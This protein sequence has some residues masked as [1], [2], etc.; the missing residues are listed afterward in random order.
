M[1]NDS[2]TKESRIW[3]GAFTL[4]YVATFVALFMWGSCS[5]TTP[6]EHMGV[7][8]DF[9]EEEMGLDDNETKVVEKPTK[10]EPTPPKGRP[11]EPK[12][13]NPAPKETPEEAPA[14]EPAMVDDL[15]EEVAPVADQDKVK[16]DEKEEEKEEKTEEPVINERGLFK[17]Q[18]TTQSETAKGA[19]TSDSVASGE[20]GDPEWKLEGRSIVGRMP[21][22]SYEN[23]HASGIVVIDITVDH[24]GKVISAVVGKGSTTS[25]AILTKEA[26]NAA[27]ATTFSASGKDFQDGSITYYF[28]RRV[29]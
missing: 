26:L 27:K 13:D 5:V 3:G 6:K 24:N 4:L 21:R 1:T 17:R 11:E 12:S 18:N 22:P 20:E 23:S 8:V 19:S 29:R 25:D 9:T 14:N 15:A 2:R 28:V 10:P 16:E 7:I